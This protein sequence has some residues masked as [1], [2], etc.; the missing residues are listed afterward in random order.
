MTSAPKKAAVV[1][2]G[3]ADYQILSPGSFVNC[4]VTGK[5]IALEDLRYWNAERQE[6]Y[7]DAATSAQRE[8]ELATKS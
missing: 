1:H 4:A 3:L 6:A 7:V 2:Y 5:A 8:R